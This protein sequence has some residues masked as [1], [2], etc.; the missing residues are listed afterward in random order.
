MFLLRQTLWSVATL[1]K[2][3]T[4][5]R[6]C[7]VCNRTSSWRVEYYTDIK[8]F[9]D[10]DDERSMLCWRDD[11]RFTQISSRLGDID[12]QKHVKESI[13]LSTKLASV[14]GHLSNALKSRWHQFASWMHLSAVQLPRWISSKTC[15]NAEQMLRSPN[16]ISF[17][18]NNR[19]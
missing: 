9:V 2:S 18:Y 6:H 15:E 7:I 4:Y 5:S 12:E 11:D 19:L 13:S 3:G 16:P 14:I 8:G 10:G 1:Y 17:P